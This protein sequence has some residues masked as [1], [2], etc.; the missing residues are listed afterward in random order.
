[1]RTPSE[2]LVGP[3]A[4]A[5]LRSVHLDLVF[6]GVHGMDGKAGFTCPN[7][8]EAETDRALIEAGRRLVVLADHSKWGVVGIASIAR[9]EQADLL[10]SDGGLDPAAQLILRES[11]RELVLVEGDEAPEAE[12]PAA[13]VAGRRAAGAAGSRAH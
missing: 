11:V 2:A 6:M 10:V 4:V 9:L 12:L 1:M 13:M 7:L 5:Q 8:L 3:F